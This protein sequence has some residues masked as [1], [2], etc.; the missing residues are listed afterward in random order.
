MIGADESPLPPIALSPFAA[1]R[2][3]ERV[4]S[5]AGVYALEFLPRR[6]FTMCFDLE[7]LEARR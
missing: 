6:Q 4:A 2:K 5:A 7:G 3:C 1:R